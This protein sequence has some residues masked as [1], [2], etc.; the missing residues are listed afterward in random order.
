MRIVE[1]GPIRQLVNAAVTVVACGGGGIPIRRT[2][3]GRIEGI[4]AVV[5]KDYAS[6][7]LAVEL[8]A[9]RMIITT[10]VDG[11]YRDFGTAEQTMLSDV[12]T[13]ELAVLEEA[14][15]FA[16]GSM[17]PKVDASIYFL[18]HGGQQVVICSPTA[19]V[20]AYHGRAGTRIRLH[21]AARDEATTRKEQ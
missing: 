20:D 14:G 2:A 8:G 16:P 13:A 15:H 17:R 1:I 9:S 19:L 10:G 5:D 6:A 18:D 4:E 21:R 3:A 7:L 12:T 11:V